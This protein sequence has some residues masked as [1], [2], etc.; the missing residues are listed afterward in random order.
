MTTSD[1]VVLDQL[2]ERFLRDLG[3][4]QTVDVDAI[5]AEWP[6]LAQRVRE[7]WALAQSVALDLARPLP[8][9]P[10][11]E[12]V[13]E[14]GRGAMG[15][16]YLARQTSVGRLLALKL[17]PGLAA[18]W[19]PGA[20]Q[21][22]LAEARALG[23][24]NHD[25]VVAI[26]DVID[27][28]GILAYAMDWIGGSSLKELLVASGPLPIQRVVQIGI[29]IASALQSLHDAGLVHR[30]VKPSNILI[31]E[32]GR[33]FLADFGLVRDADSSLTQTGAFVG[34]LAY[35]APEQHRGLALDARA[36]V[37]SLGA[38][39]YEALTGALPFAARTPSEFLTEA[40]RGPKPL[41]A[42]VPHASRD[43]ATILEHALEPEALNRYQSAGEL[44]ADLDRMLRFEP[45][46]ARPVG[47]VLRTVR[48]GRRHRRTVVASLA[49]AFVV[50]VLAMLAW[51]SVEY[52]RAAV[53]ERA[54]KA[55][56]E[57][58]T[59]RLLL[60]AP[61]A[62]DPGFEQ[63]S[64]DVG[65]SESGQQLVVAPEQVQELLEHYRQ[66]IANGAE[67]GAEL[68]CRV[69][70]ALAALDEPLALFTAGIRQHVGDLPLTIAALKEARLHDKLSV[71]SLTD[72]DPT[73]RR[74][75]GLVGFLMCS[76]QLAVAA[77]S[78][79]ALLDYPDPL[80]DVCLG[81]LYLADDRGALAL[82][83]LLRSRP[84]FTNSAFLGAELAAAAL[85][86]G[87]LE[88]AR[89]A[90]DQ[91]ASLDLAH[92]R[93][94]RFL[95]DLVEADLLHARGDRV[96]ARARY[97]D[98]ESRHS[99]LATQLRLGELDLE[100]GRRDESIKRLDALKD[101][102]PFVPRIRLALARAAIATGSLK[103]Y[104]RQVRYVQQREWPELREHSRWPGSVRCLLEIL[105]IGGLVAEYRE[106][107]ELSGL[108]RSG[109]TDLIPDGSALPRPF[110]KNELDQEL[111]A[112]SR[113]QE[114]PEQARLPGPKPFRTIEG[115]L[116]FYRLGN[117]LANVGDIDGDHCADLLIGNSA[118]TDSLGRGA[119][120]LFGAK[121]EQPLCK[122]PS[123][124]TAERRGVTVAAA[125]DLNGD[126]VPDVLIAADANERG[127]VEA[128]AWSRD[129]KKWSVL[130]RCYDAHVSAAPQPL[131]GPRGDL[132]GILICM[133]KGADGRMPLQLVDGRAGTQIRSWTIPGSGVVAVAPDV[134]GDGNQDFL[135]GVPE[136]TGPSGPRS[137]L[138]QLY[139]SARIAPPLREWSGEA[140]EANFGMSL[141]L[142]PDVDR[143]GMPDVLVGASM[144]DM[145]QR[146]PGKAY[147]YSLRTGKELH[148][149]VGAHD[150]DAACLVTPVGDVN[151]DGFEDIAIASVDAHD[152]AGKVVIYSGQNLDSEL[153]TIQGYPEE[154]LGLA[155]SGHGTVCVGDWDHDGCADFAVPSGQGWGTKGKQAGRVQLFHGDRNWRG[156]VRR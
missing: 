119:A 76:A 98:L 86:S 49:G 110:P 145:K 112:L 12:I 120:F 123:V 97:E 8:T 40:E 9:V 32:D 155:D 81:M 23:R 4:G 58:Q 85:A 144:M 47:M 143:D 113:E 5:C 29:A 26:H 34:T 100:E 13:A 70:Q 124:G 50:A 146:G 138:V 148:S 136:S 72:A 129:D 38:T 15:V 153:V 83:Y 84:D 122:F 139:S 142:G 96:A 133:R 130:W 22:F 36:D 59:A 88:F 116:P 131:T 52:D 54:A 48:W 92:D 80:V 31:R 20:R 60:I 135:V 152:G 137:G 10:G 105:R 63:L 156:T 118:T 53:R 93:G 7:V 16:V 104:A 79:P 39:L 33:P 21:R 87:N 95:A 117:S 115:E 75:L 55:R 19:S 24:V 18:V 107:L 103:L 147:V 68:E 140:A 74:A 128:L 65:P 150:G 43:L 99:T 42:S 61:F 132:L 125:G 51:W 1:E 149:W 67:A 11:F 45:I 114:A 109:W 151:G 108:E 82:P 106:G 77:W 154:R 102:R 90:L 121:Q 25:H 78:T 28:N 41:R 30:D 64:R 141:H 56:S 57:L 2:L 127:C 27:G 14:I 66:A 73:D 44:A 89:G 71:P 134:D 46:R 62:Q 17:L 3:A 6:R 111:V 37:F 69:I 91:V 126:G 94:G 35:A 101:R